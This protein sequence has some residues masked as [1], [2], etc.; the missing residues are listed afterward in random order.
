MHGGWTR[1]CPPL[2]DMSTLT[3]HHVSDSTVQL[4]HRM[5]RWRMSTHKVDGLGQAR[6]EDQPINRKNRGRR[7]SAEAFLTG[8][9]AGE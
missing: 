9:G 7:C 6:L 5:W 3:S 4:S 2:K 8:C 1:S